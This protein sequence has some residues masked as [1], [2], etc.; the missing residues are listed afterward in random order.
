MLFLPQDVV[1][2]LSLCGFKI[3]C[4]NSW[5]KIPSKVIKQQKIPPLAWEFPK[6]QIAGACE[7]TLEKLYD[8]PCTLP[9]AETTLFGDMLLR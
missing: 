1:D 3:T 9:Q 5:K 4:I 2:A 7:N 6:P 8:C